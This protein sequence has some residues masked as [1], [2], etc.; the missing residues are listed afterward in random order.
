MELRKISQ[1]RRLFKTHVGN[2]AGCHTG[3]QEVGRCRTRDESEEQHAGA[4]EKS[5]NPAWL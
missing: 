3:R 5:K 4:S 1:Q 2:A